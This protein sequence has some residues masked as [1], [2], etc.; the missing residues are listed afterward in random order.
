MELAA[1]FGGST[2]DS[3]DKFSRCGWTDGPA[4]M[5]ILS[6]AT[7]WFVGRIQARWDL[8]DHWGHLLDPI[9]GDAPECI[10]EWLTFSSVRDLTPGHEA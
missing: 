2:E 10:G 4:N 9:A 3:I 6:D 5:P 1:L 8:G 7:A